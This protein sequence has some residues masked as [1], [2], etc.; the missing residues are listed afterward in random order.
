MANRLQPVF[1]EQD[2]EHFWE[3]AKQGEL[4]YQ[5]CNACDTV[6]FTPRAHCT[7]CGSDD[8]AWKVSAGA[9]EVYTY[10]V[11]RQN[12]SPAFADLGAYA[13][14][15]IDLDEGFR[16]MSGIVGVGDPTQEV[17]IGMRVQVEFEPQES[18]EYPIPVFR[19]V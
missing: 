2:T 4:R 11:V 13:V 15:Y 18:G 1:P 17:R 10:S 19:P 14:A 8:L 5:Q 3:G 12:R 9:G 7:A 6:V 16:M